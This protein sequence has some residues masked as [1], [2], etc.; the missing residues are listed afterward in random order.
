MPRKIVLPPV[1]AKWV[2]KFAGQR[3][4]KVG[5]IEGD[6]RQFEMFP[7]LE[8]EKADIAQG[9]QPAATR[10]RVTKKRPKADKPPSAGG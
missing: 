9:T 3:A 5:G 4:A 10:A 8:G 6:T 2:A 1:S 7:S